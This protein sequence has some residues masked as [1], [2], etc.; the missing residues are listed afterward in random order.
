MRP[1][2]WVAIAGLWGSAALAGPRDLLILPDEADRFSRG[3]DQPVVDVPWWLGFN[4]PMLERVIEEGISANPDVASADSRVAQAQGAMW[5]TRAGLLPSVTADATGS[6]APLRSLGFQFGAGA[7]AP[8]PAGLFY[9]YGI[10]VGAQWQVDLFG[11][12]WLAYR[13]A[14]NEGDA[15]AAD[16]DQ[17]VLSL[18]ATLGE[19]YFDVLSA[20]RTEAV[21]IEQQQIA[22]ALLEVIEL[23]YDRA[24]AEGLVVLQQRSQAAG[25]EVFV[26]QSRMSRELAEQRL[27]VLLGRQPRDVVDNVPD[28]FPALPTQPTVGTPSEL[29][30]RRP[31]LLAAQERMDASSQRHQS[32]FSG[33]LPTVSVQADAGRDWLKTTDTFSQNAWSAGGS[34]RLP[35]FNGGRATGA[36]RQARAGEY[37]AVA[38]YGRLILQAQGEVEGALAREAAMVERLDAVQR[39]AE[40]SRLTFEQSQDRYLRGLDA[41]VNVLV[42]QNNLRTAETSLVTAERDVLAARVALHT[43]LGGQW[44]AS[45]GF[46]GEGR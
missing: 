11:R 5:Q 15:A 36:I 6:T 19:A 42:A 45:F 33:V 30:V 21:A 46:E 41:F 2:L 26:T 37:G 9:S 18:S 4:D 40:L 12:S 17:F 27:A 7:G 3:V 16:R 29:L 14:A 44:A 23:R 25:A 35:I 20:R 34:V 32:A 10:G 8:P 31:D 39:Q 28:T 24:S 22:G 1:A 13:A 43:A 38:S